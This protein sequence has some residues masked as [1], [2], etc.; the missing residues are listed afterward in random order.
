MGKEAEL[1]ATAEYHQSI[2]CCGTIEETVR[3]HHATDLFGTAETKL[4]DSK[5]YKRLGSEIYIKLADLHSLQPELDVSLFDKPNQKQMVKMIPFERKRSSSFNDLFDTK[6]S[7]PM[8][9]PHVT[10]NVACVNGIFD[11][12]LKKLRATL[13]DGNGQPAKN[14]SD[15]LKNG[16]SENGPSQR[17]YQSILQKAN[18]IR[19]QGGVESLRRKMDE[20]TKILNEIKEIWINCDYLLNEENKDDTR[21]R[22]QFRGK[23]T[24]DPFDESCETLRARA[25]TYREFIRK[26]K[27][28]DKIARNTFDKHATA[29]E[30]LVAEQ[31]AAS[32]GFFAAIN[33]RSTEREEEKNV[34]IN[35]DPD[36]EHELSQCESTEKTVNNA[37]DIASDNEVKN[38]LDEAY[39]CYKTLNTDMNCANIFYNDLTQLMDDFHKQ[40]SDLCSARKAE[41]DGLLWKLAGQIDFSI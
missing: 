8:N 18:Y 12:E 41:K 25:G 17:D 35:A 5:L 26:A 40:V 34:D 31:S 3:L 21:L 28:A 14:S 38:H 19:D 2:V 36:T 15:G 20:S 24:L 23:W 10:A 22:E 16:I 6:L 32:I 1:Y 37:D 39:D 29:M 13:G 30:Q 4:S 9:Y 33:S 27:L 7:E 11:V